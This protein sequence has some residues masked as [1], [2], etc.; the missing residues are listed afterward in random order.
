MLNAPAHGICVI[1]NERNFAHGVPGASCSSGLAVRDP[2]SSPT[3]CEVSG[4]QFPESV[5]RAQLTLKCHFHTP[6][7]SLFCQFTWPK[8]IM[9][10]SVEWKEHRQQDSLQC[11][12]PQPPLQCEAEQ[13]KS[14]NNQKRRQH[15]LKLLISGIRNKRV[16]RVITASRGL[17]YHT[18]FLW[19]N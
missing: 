12:I 10:F 9:C 1:L 18:S 8:S 19:A 16:C 4:P 6:S 13:H 7:H 5:R 17:V 11:T 14:K 15:L 3:H 2:I